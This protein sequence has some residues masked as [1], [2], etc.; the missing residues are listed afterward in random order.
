M[1]KYWTVALTGWQDSLVYRFNAFIWVLYA[2]LPS[3]TVML[4]WLAAYQTHPGQPIGGYDLSGMMTYYFYVT[5]LSI[6][7]TPHPEW[8]IAQQIRDGKIT[9]FIVRPIGFYGYRLAQESAYQIVKSLMMLPA[10]ALM[11]LLFRHYL[12]TPA[13]S[14][15]ESAC[16]ILACSLAYLLLSQ[17][18]FLLGISAFWVTEPGGFLEIWNVLMGVF[19]GRMLPLTLLPMWLRT[20][21]DALPF[22]VLYAFP[23]SILQGT[24]TMADLRL[25][26]LRQ[27]IWLVI[28]S[29]LVRLAWQRGLLAYEAYGG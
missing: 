19:A 21:G 1:K 11:L 29:A 17:L 22:S 27:L 12:R 28:L 7:I 5:L 4:V 13:L 18:K 14:T 24:A 20:I 15:A 16:F 26:F 9:Q 3:V 8:E 2:L 6:V 10:A 23:M 25:G